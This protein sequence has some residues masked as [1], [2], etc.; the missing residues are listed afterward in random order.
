[1]NFKYVKIN[2]MKI[3]EIQSDS[4]RNSFCDSDDMHSKILFRVYATISILL[5]ID[6]KT[7][8]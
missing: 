8:H 2:S 7:V 6:Y 4:M 5:A 1:M 3:D